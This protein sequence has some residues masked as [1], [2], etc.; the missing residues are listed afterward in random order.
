VRASGG[1]AVLRH[2]HREAM[3]LEEVDSASRAPILKRYLQLAPGAR[4]HIPVDPQA[5]LADF[6]TV[7]PRY[8]VFRVRPDSPSQA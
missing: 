6:E 1:H 2:G 3:R 5:P 8:P 7:A 4:A